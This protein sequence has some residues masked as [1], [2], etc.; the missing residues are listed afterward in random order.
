MFAFFTWELFYGPK[1][2]GGKVF[3]TS[4]IWKDEVKNIIQL[5]Y[6]ES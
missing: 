6:D 2:G 4:V 1:C 5:K 3:Y